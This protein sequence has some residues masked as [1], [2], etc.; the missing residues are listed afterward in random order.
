MH[1]RF[2]KVFFIVSTLWLVVLTVK[3]YFF[4][5]PTHQTHEHHHQNETS[6]S[7]HQHDHDIEVEKSIDEIIEEQAHKESYDNLPFV[8]KADLVLRSGSL[9]DFKELIQENGI[10]STNV[11]TPSDE[12]GRTLLTRAAFEGKIEMIKYIIEELKAGVNIADKDQITPIMEAVSTE[13]EDIVNY[14]I[15]QGADIHATN[16]LGADALTMALSGSSEHI[17]SRLLSKGANP[18]HKWNKKSFS[19]LMLASRNGHQMSVKLLLKAGAAVNDKDV[20][21]NT[22]LHYASAEGF[23]QIVKILLSAQASPNAKNAKGLSPKDIAAKNGF[24]NIEKLF[25]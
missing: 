18:N 11:N 6:K 20:D 15:D 24:S 13:N 8:H 14:L 25:P 17:V 19:H 4:Q 23:D 21:G 7:D 12:D 16:K 22:A 10:D 5:P 1:L 3:N 2:F 9:S